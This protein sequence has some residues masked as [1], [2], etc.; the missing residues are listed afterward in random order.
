MC[1][2]TPLSTYLLFFYLKNASLFHLSASSRPRIATLTPFSGF[3][4][5]PVPTMKK[6]SAHIYCLFIYLLMK[7]T[8]LVHGHL[9]MKMRRS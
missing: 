5:S 2:L 1:V 7:I 3:G 9:Q 8:Y 6:P 4:S